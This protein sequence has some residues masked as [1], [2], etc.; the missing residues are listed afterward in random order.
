LMD[1]ATRSHSPSAAQSRLVAFVSG[2]RSVRKVFPL[3]RV[4]AISKCAAAM[5][6]NFPARSRR[7]R[8]TLSTKG[9]S[10]SRHA[11]PP[12]ML[13]NSSQVC[14]DTLHSLLRKPSYF[15]GDQLIEILKVEAVFE[16]LSGA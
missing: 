9:E 5:E 4:T 11:K 12:G 3:H 1:E 15:L 7:Q 8:Q 16:G 13:V 2:P 6:R 10:E 14:L